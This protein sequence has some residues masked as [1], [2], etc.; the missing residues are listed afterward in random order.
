MKSKLFSSKRLDKLNRATGLKENPDHSAQKNYLIYIIL[1]VVLLVVIIPDSGASITEVDTIRT[2]NSPSQVAM[3]V[4]GGASF[5]PIVSKSGGSWSSGSDW[6]MLAA[7]PERTSWSP[8]EVRGDLKVDWYRPIEPYIPYK[9][10]PI[11]VNGK[12]YVSTARGLYAFNAN[13]GD[14]SS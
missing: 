14:L 3:P 8:E 2:I 13:D 12:I 10:Q 5:L 6:P 4:D 11:A 9:V 7:N 1:L